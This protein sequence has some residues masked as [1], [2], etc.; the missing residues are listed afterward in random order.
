MLANLASFQSNT[1][2]TP[3]QIKTLRLKRIE[4]HE[5]FF[6]IRTESNQKA[7]EV[8]M[9]AFKLQTL[10]QLMLLFPNLVRNA[11]NVLTLTIVEEM[12]AKIYE[13]FRNHRI[14]TVHY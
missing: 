9:K 13:R 8:E 3:N 4:L 10:Y 7:A 1:E 14:G 5:A 11:T 12:I 6:V 2:A